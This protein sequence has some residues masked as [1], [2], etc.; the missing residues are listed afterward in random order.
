MKTSDPVEVIANLVSDKLKDDEL[1]FGVNIDTYLSNLAE[2]FPKVSVFITS[3][4]DRTHTLNKNIHLVQ[5]IITAALQTKNKTLL[6]PF[7]EIL[8]SIIT[9]FQRYPTASLYSESDIVEMEV[10][11]GN[12]NSTI[13]TGGAIVYAKEVQIDLS[14]Q[15]DDY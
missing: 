4:S 3:F 5:Y 11:T 15:Y 1:F 14:K 7:E 13:D 12:V 6:H 8:R 10:T 9:E 2:N